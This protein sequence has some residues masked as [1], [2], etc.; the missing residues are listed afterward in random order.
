MTSNVATN[1]SMLYPSNSSTTT[2][3]TSNGIDG[4]ELY[5]VQTEEGTLTNYIPSTDTF[6]SRLGNATYVD[7]NGL[8]KTN[9]KNYVKYSQDFDNSYWSISGGTI[10]S[11]FAEAPDGTQTAAKVTINTGGNTYFGLPNTLNTLT[12]GKTYT[13]SIWVKSTGVSSHFTMQANASGASTIYRL[14]KTPT[15]TEW[16]RYS[17]TFVATSATQQAVY[18]NNYPDDYSV[19]ALIWGAQVNEGSEPLDYV[20]TTTVESGAPRYSHDPE[21]LVPT[22]LYLEPAATNY[23][24]QYPT[25]G[26][27][28]TL[29]LNADTAPDGSNTAIKVTQDSSSNTTHSVY[30][31]FYNTS[32]RNWTLSAFVKPID[33]YKVYFTFN[34]NVGA[35]NSYAVFDLSNGTIQSEGNTNVNA[36]IKPYQNGWYRITIH[37]TGTSNGWRNQQVM[38]YKD[39]AG[40]NGLQFDGDST[41]SFLVWGFQ[42][43]QGTSEPTSYIYDTGTT[44]N[45]ITRPADTYTSTA[46][47]VLDRDG[48]NKIAPFNP[49][50]YTFGVEYMVPHKTG[51]TSANGFINQNTI[52]SVTD[53]SATQ[54]SEIRH[55]GSTNGKYRIGHQNGSN[56]INMLALFNRGNGVYNVQEKG[57]IGYDGDETRGY[58]S[59]NGVL[60]V[61]TN[62][63]ITQTTINKILLGAR[64]WDSQVVNS[65]IQ[66][67]YFWKTRLPNTAL[68]NITK[69]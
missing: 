25:T 7:S 19:E 40:S 37:N 9:P 12:P 21:T 51:Y 36:S 6:T 65:S 22:G 18:F 31:T 32:S 44:M 27:N 39:G 34:S 49:S 64:P 58:A 60:E 66:R 63:G 30:R 69:L 8:I 59:A 1:I 53:G 15:P 26:S 33:W 13:W 45:G 11:N 42:I 52:L 68:T 14:A 29:T 3:F 28:S 48:G 55:T 43:E 38:F 54:R 67:I 4:I 10:T 35:A 5:G 50:E 57:I 62:G 17:V 20:K 2:H 41:S 16:T 24:G 23:F 47:T 46:T 56:I 61:G